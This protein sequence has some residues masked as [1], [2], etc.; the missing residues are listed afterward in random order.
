MF[1]QTYLKPVVMNGKQNESESLSIITQ[2]NHIG[3]RQHISSNNKILLSDGADLIAGTYGL[4]NDYTKEHERNI[5]PSTER[6]VL[7]NRISLFVCL[8]V[9]NRVERTFPARR[10]TVRS[11]DAMMGNLNPQSVSLGR[12]W[13]IRCQ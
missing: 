9:C 10:L 3:R 8:C 11:L 1:L 13:L 4:Y 12:G 5:I 2:T 6:R 7:R